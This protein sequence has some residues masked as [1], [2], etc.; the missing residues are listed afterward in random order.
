MISFA[1]S[2]PAIVAGLLAAN[3]IMEL[4][5]SRKDLYQTAWRM[6]GHGD[7]VGAALYGGEILSAPGVADASCL[8][9]QVDLDLRAVVFIPEM[10]GATHAARA[11]LP[12]TIPL[13]RRGLPACGPILI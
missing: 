11:A 12:P 7:N 5:L 3:E 1:A 4:G 6:E 2:K 8:S 9:A 13:T 10:T